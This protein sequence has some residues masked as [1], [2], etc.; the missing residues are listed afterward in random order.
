MNVYRYIYIYKLRGGSRQKRSIVQD[1]DV[2]SNF[3]ELPE[4]RM[5]SLFYRYYIVIYDLILV[6]PKTMALCR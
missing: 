3:V 1:R 6:S 2:A 4:I 5:L